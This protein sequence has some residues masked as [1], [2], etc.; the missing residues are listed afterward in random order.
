MPRPLIPAARK[1]CFRRMIVGAVVPSRSLIALKE[2]PF[3]Q[4]QNQL[5]AEQKAVTRLWDLSQFCRLLVG[6]GECGATLARANQT[7][8][9]PMLAMP[10]C[11][12]RG[13]RALRGLRDVIVE[14]QTVLL[15]AAIRAHGPRF[16]PS[17]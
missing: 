16:I 4:R 12:L 14:S 8:I 1:R 11:V 3:V 10:A 17:D 13:V 2:V 15:N 6:Q 9:E 7:G 5:G